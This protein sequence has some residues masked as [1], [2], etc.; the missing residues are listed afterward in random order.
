MKHFTEMQDMNIHY[1]SAPASFDIGQKIRIPHQVL[2]ETSRQGTCLD[3]AVLCASALE[4][5]SLNALLVLGPGHA[6]AAV[7][8]P[9]KSFR[10]RVVK[11]SDYTADDW[12]ML[13][14]DILPIECTTFT[15]GRDIGFEYAVSVGNKN[16][17]RIENITDVYWSRICGEKPV[18]TFTDEP[19]CDTPENGS[20]P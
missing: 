2:H 17:E 20:E 6:F 4:A 12:K 3:L 7:W 14:E 5:A 1:L 8:L 15:D 9:N 16:M 13:R 18:Y 19:I 10:K 11:P